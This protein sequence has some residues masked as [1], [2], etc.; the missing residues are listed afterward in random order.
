[1]RKSYRN[2]VKLRRMRQNL[3]GVTDLE[4]FGT[5]RNAGVLERDVT[6]LRRLCGR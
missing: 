2:T 4:L 1:M 3:I 5:A 6:I